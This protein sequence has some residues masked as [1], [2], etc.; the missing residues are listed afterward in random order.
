MSNQVSD[1]VQRVDILEQTW[2]GVV[3]RLQ[4]MFSKQSKITNKDIQV[5]PS[6]DP[7]DIEYL[8]QQ[9]ENVLE[10][11]IIG[12]SPVGVAPDINSFNTTA[13][14]RDG[15][16]IQ[17]DKDRANWIVLRVSPVMLTFQV[18]FVTE[19]VLTLMRIIDRWTSNEIWGF[20]IKHNNWGVKIQVQADKNLQVPP[21][22]PTSGNVRQFR[23]STNLQAKSYSGYA[24]FIPSIRYTEIQTLIPLKGTIEDAL[25]NPEVLAY[26]V[27]T[28]VINSNP[29][30]SPVDYEP[31]A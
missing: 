28:Q 9:K 11:P 24:W 18:V 20:E 25:Q 26:T 14:R 21:R 19:D 17:F 5:I 6:A 8:Q 13:M 23:L 7:E 27:N 30:H 10:L 15:Y 16:P 2:L 22:T 3:N 29:L 1:R 4:Q 31:K 12:V